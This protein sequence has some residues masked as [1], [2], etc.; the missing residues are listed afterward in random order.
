MF[1]AT[2]SIPIGCTKVYKERTLDFSM[3]EECK[4]AGGAVGGDVEEGEIS[5]SASV[6][7][8]SEE[9]FIKQLDSPSTIPVSSTTTT[10]STST[11]K[12]NPNAN[13]ASEPNPKTTRV[14]TMRD[15]YNNY[16]ISRGYARGLYNLAW[17]QAVQNKPLDELFVM[18]KAEA[19][20]SVN[21]SGGESKKDGTVE[22]CVSD[23]VVIDVE[24]NVKEEGELEEGE[25][26]LDSEIFENGDLKE[27]DSEAMAVDDLGNKVNLIREGLRTVTVVEA[28]K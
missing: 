8:I 17:A 7:E 13:V 11:A 21:G 12:V 9:A 15:L 1:V 26:D 14:W 16:P 25:I 24:D 2:D 3:E 28:E 5:D 22:D 6:E 23:K 10:S 27:V 18:K 20:G 4:T 19:D